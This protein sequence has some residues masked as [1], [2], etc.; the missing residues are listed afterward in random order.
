MNDALRPFSAPQLASRLRRLAA[1]PVATLLLGTAPLLA[2][3]SDRDDEEATAQHRV[4]TI[5]SLSDLEGLE[6]LEGLKGLGGLEALKALEGLKGLGG[7]AGLEGLSALRLMDCGEGEDCPSY[8]NLGASGGFLGVQ[9]SA[10]TEELRAH[11]GAPSETGTLVSRVIEDSPAARAGIQVGD[12]IT[13]VNGE[14]IRGRGQ[15]GSLIRKIEG[16][17]PADIEIIRDRRAEVVTATIEARQ[18]ATIEL[19]GLIDQSVTH[20]LESLDLG[21]IGDALSG[22]DFSGIA[23]LSVGVLDE[24]ELEDA[25]SAI[26]HTFESDEWK[27]YVTRLENLDFSE[28]EVRME[29]LQERME[30]LGRELERKR[31]ERRRR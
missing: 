10:L 30:E 1:L 2:Q 25:L 21:V 29:E 28:L 17:A 11:F 5:D 20:A 7:L 8:L 22:L 31:N 6:A 4:I 24:A 9:T 14:R 12:I 15:L 19:S 27:G 18:R 23:N 13:S 3:T 26:T 16:D